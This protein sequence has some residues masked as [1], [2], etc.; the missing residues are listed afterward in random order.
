[1]S[2]IPE[3]FNFFFFLYFLLSLFFSQK[4]STT[5]WINSAIVKWL[6]SF[7]ML[8]FVFTPIIQ[9]HVCTFWIFLPS[10]SFWFSYL[11]F[12]S[13][14]GSSNSTY[15]SREL[16]QGCQMLFLYFKTKNPYLGQFWRALNRKIFGIFDD[17]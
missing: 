9:I 14:H 1:M 2:R 10:C 4:H 6:C 16:K 8:L 12:F 7:L 11:P 3:I 13:Y 5:E 17:H 15:S